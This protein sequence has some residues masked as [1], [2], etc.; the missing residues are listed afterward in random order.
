MPSDR[1]SASEGA[2]DLTTRYMG[3]L[4][5]NPLIASASPLTGEIGAIR[6]FE[7]GGAAAV[8]LPSIFEEQIEQEVQEYEHLTGIALDS[9]P[10]VASFFPDPS[11]YHIGPHQYLELIRR[12]VD[13]VEI[14]VI[15]SLNGTTS[16]GWIN[17][18]KLIEEAGARAIELNIYFIPTDLG[19]TGRAVEQKYLEI[20]R[21]VHEAIAIPIAVK[22]HPY[23]SAVGSMV[24]DLARAGADA[25]V[26]FNRFYQ[27][28]ID[29]VRLRLR[30]DLRLSEPS[31]IRL[32]LLWIKTLAGRIDASLAASTGVESA[33]EIVKYL[34][35]GADVV[36]T[37]SSLLRHGIDHLRVLVN[38]LRTWCA[39]REF[40]SLSRFRGLLS[41]HNMQNPSGLERAHY[42]SILQRYSDAAAR[43]HPSPEAAW[44]RSGDHARDKHENHLNPER[45]HMAEDPTSAKNCSDFPEPEGCCPSC[46]MDANVGAGCLLAIHRKDASVYARVCCRKAEVAK[47]ALAREER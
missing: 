14:P 44:R 26:L 1:N 35:V 45:T 40:D 24:M 38:D 29:L 32:P 42:I 39:T 47:R 20:V 22:L 3:L 8:V 9:F 10:E 30:N 23:F 43:H 2:V 13:A 6:H 34:L 37:T 5:K 41:Q 21:A 16:E 4:L 7:D 33:E 11:L 31:E 17:Y 19:M 12:A 36:M 18:A 46:H 27:P 15:A 28:N 25:F